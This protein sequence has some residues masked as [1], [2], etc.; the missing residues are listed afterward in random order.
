VKLFGWLVT[1]KGASGK[2]SEVI[3]WWEMRRIPYNIIV[4]AVGLVSIFL[5][6]V[7]GNAVVPPGEDFVEPMAMFLAVPLFLIAANLGYTLGWIVEILVVRGE[8]ENH[9]VFRR[10]N[11]KRALGVSCAFP[12]F[13]IV[14]P[15]LSW[16]I[17]K[18]YG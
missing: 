4:C 2:A 18:L 6:E 12:S 13:L 11:F 9:R 17:Q 3:L 15:A 7:F 16:M 5:M 1:A 14:A 8:S 10:K